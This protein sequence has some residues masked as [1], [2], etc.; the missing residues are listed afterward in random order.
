MRFHKKTLVSELVSTVGESLPF[1]SQVSHCHSPP[2]CAT[3][4]HLPGESL[5]STSMLNS[6][7]TAL[8]A[9]HVSPKT[10]VGTSSGYLSTC[11][12]QALAQVII[13]VYY[14]TSCSPITCNNALSWPVRD[15]MTF[16]SDM[17]TDQ[18]TNDIM[19]ITQINTVPS[20][21]LF[22]ELDLVVTEY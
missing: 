1:T 2:R 18:I 9:K 12:L 22:F 6:A 16:L 8:S 19:L 13:M 4:I 15:L 5:S 14:T 20:R 11:K 3:V 17:S 21:V 7:K 10:V